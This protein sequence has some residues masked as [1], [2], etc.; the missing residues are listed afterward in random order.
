MNS[1]NR[2]FDRMF[3][4]IVNENKQFEKDVLAE[5]RTK[6]EFNRKQKDKVTNQTSESIGELIWHIKINLETWEEEFIRS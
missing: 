4:G 6:A 5:W 3:P 1:I 2:K